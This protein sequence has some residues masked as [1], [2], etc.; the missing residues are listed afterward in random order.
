M[1]WFALVLRSKASFLRFNNAP[2]ASGLILER[3]LD[4]Q[5]VIFDPDLHISDCPGECEL[6]LLV[7]GEADRSRVFPS[8]AGFRPVCC[9]SN[10][11]SCYSRAGVQSATFR[12]SQPTVPDSNLLDAKR[13]RL[14]SLVLANCGSASFRVSGAIQTRSLSGFLD[15]RLISILYVLIGVMVVS[16]VYILIWTFRLL[17]ANPKIAFHHKLLISSVASSAVSNLALIAFLWIRHTEDKRFTP[18]LIVGGI[19]WGISRSVIAFLTLVSLQYPAEVAVRPF[20]LAGGLL[21]LAMI[22][23]N[24]G[25]ANFDVRQSGQWGLGYGRVSYAQF[26]VLSLFGFWLIV[27]A[28]G[29]P[30]PENADLDER[31]CFLMMIALGFFV[32][33]GGSLFV[34]ATRVG[35]SLEETRKVEW[36]PMTLEIVY[37]LITLFVNGWFWL[38]FNPQGWQA[39]AVEGGDLGTAEVED[40]DSLVGSGARFASRQRRPMPD[41]VISGN[42]DNIV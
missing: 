12:N 3:F 10:F 16:V 19:L 31:K 40:V 23:E 26:V 38:R 2:F 30:P 28:G 20:C 7:F 36:I 9:S 6:A 15:E 39:L 25:L 24:F 41:V 4:T 35:A 37:F 33:F 17:G 32:Y 14:Y 5:G 22:G 18:F 13:P 11:S 21:A 8:S 1:L 29:T 42:D 27:F 34:A